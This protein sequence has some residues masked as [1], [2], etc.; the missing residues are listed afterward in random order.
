MNHI[1]KIFQL[2]RQADPQCFKPIRRMKRFPG[3]TL[4]E[5]LVVCAIIAI[6][7]AM[8]LPALS[9]V[10]KIAGE[11][12]CGNN[13]KHMGTA[14]FMYTTDNNDWL[15]WQQTYL[16]SNSRWYSLLNPYLEPNL[17]P[18]WSDIP[19]TMFCP[20]IRWGNT[21]YGSGMG[22]YIGYGMNFRVVP[23]NM[24]ELGARKLA[25]VTKPS[26][27]ILVGDNAVSTQENIAPDFSSRV[28]IY[29][30]SETPSGLGITDWAAN[31]QK[32][33]KGKK[34][35]WAEGHISWERLDDLESNYNKSQTWWKYNQ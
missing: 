11:V 32:H 24:N 22:S 29:H 16:N 3:F 6:L 9:N 2:S 35:L 14:L 12:S 26:D 20:S 10:K 19:K 33:R 8:L 30:P 15:M 28:G 25:A 27:T 13:L 1:E 31:L 4:I 17:S 23:A 18:I 34:I 21:G 7:A 5:L